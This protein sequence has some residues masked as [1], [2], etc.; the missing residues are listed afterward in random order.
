MNNAKPTDSED[1]L[2]YELTIN[3]TGFVR[4]VGVDAN[5][6]IVVHAVIRHPTLPPILCA[7]RFELTGIRCLD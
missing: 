4:S 6:T 1:E 5:S 3:N 2:C 7:V